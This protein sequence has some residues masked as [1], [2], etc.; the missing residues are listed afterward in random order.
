MMNVNANISMHVLYATDGKI[1][2]FI[3]IAI[4]GPIKV[5]SHKMEL[6]YLAICL[7]F[8]IENVL[9]F[10]PSWAKVCGLK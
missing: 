7:R 9:L 4:A 2:S 5:Q 8:C 6:R 1:P 3:P 10:E